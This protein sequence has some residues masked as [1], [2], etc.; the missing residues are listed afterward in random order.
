MET[1]WQDIRY[2]ARMLSKGRGF[3]VVAILTLALGIGAN[4]AIFS[5]INATSLARLPYRQA[6]RLVMVWEHHAGPGNSFFAHNVVSPGNF[7][8]W[9]EQNTV[10]DQMAAFQ[11]FNTIITGAGE[12]EQVPAQV[13]TANMFS[14]LGVNATKGRLFLPEEYEKGKDNVVI[15]SDGMWRRKFGADPEI[16]GKK[17]LLNGEAQTIVGV[18]PRGFQL[19]IREGSIAGVNAQL[20]TPFAFSPE[21][22]TPRGRYMLAAAR[23]KPG[24]TL[25]QAQSQMDSITA[26][27]AEQYPD[28]DKGWGVV[29]VRLP[30]EFTYKIRTALFLLFGA[31]GFVLL[32]ACA[33]VANLVL[34][35]ATAR[36][37]ELAIRAALG[38]TRWRTFRQL[39]TESI[40][41]AFFGGAFGILLGTW[42]T[43]ALLALSP[44]GLLEVKT[45][46]LD[47]RVFF[48]TAALALLTG[49][50]FGLVP[51][52]F[53]TPAGLIEALQESGRTP[54]SSARASRLRHSFVIAEIA[55][56]VVL[57]TGAGLLV[58]SFLRLT[59]VSPGF[60]PQNLLTM[61]IQLSGAKYSKEGQSTTFFHELLKRVRTLPGVVAASGIN[62]MPLT[63]MGPATGVQVEGHPVLPIS[64]QPTAEVSV[65]A[66]DYFR[67][68]RIPLLRGREF[69]EK[70]EAEMSHVVI[71]NET[72]ARKVFPNEDPLGKR[73]S[74]WMKD[75]NPLCEI[76]GIV[77]D[78]KHY[79]L[80]VETQ[81]MVYWPDP[82]LPYP[83]MTLAIRTQTAPLQVAG[84]V[85]QVVGSMDRD[86]PVAE[87]RPMDDWLADSVA[88]ARF[89]TLL[90]SIFA[91]VACLLA[92]VGIYGVMA[93]AVTQRTHEIGVRMALGAQSRDVLS[94]I[95]GNGLKI[96]IAGVALG[97]AGAFALTRLLASLLFEMT[98]TDPLTFTIV[99]IA[100]TI[101]AL[102]A[103]GLPAHRATKVDPMV[104]LRYE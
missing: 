3:T 95:V 74:I 88:Q 37:R 40:L 64:E 103:C 70:E 1:L 56:S 42:G 62:A 52:L 79:G 25:S 55:L 22:R 73:V 15:L 101:V 17:L 83:W 31:V 39:L 72:M 47:P 12:P 4:S 84:A 28:M 9:Q 96:T 82:E 90:L 68:M 60:D 75:V 23:L 10:F 8:N 58:R 14:L 98:P 44:K 38:A 92:V 11:D 71:I 100:L 51:A 27:L 16:I 2:G 89:S 91:G 87:V 5:V 45:V 63:G 77:G 41:L 19:F 66:P 43:D 36:R 13:V 33:N 53:S 78:V 21:S 32:I 54:A 29:L 57:L 102:A 7:I 80:D 48:F 93:Y 34:A 50:G 26:H 20:W 99:A 69:T 85:R 61:K 30:D 49:I 18:M 46:G 24:V 76:I 81:P 104:A 97:L 6:D 94:M 59:A 35:R 86:L 65:V 67:T